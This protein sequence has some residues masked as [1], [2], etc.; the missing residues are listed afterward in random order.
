MMKN[1]LRLGL[2]LLV[3]SFAACS[4]TSQSYVDQLSG[5]SITRGRITEVHNLSGELM[6]TFSDGHAV[7]VTQ[8]GCKLAITF[9]DRQT[10]IMEVQPGMIVVHGYADDFVLRSEF[11]KPVPTPTIPTPPIPTH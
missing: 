5:Y 3:S 1:T 9:P 11:A 2:V 7:T 8:P 6:A 4:T 10:K